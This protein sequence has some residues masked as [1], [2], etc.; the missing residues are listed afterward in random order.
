[1]EVKICPL[2]WH[3]ASRGDGLVPG[4]LQ[5]PAASGEVERVQVSYSLVIPTG[6]WPVS[7]RG[8]CKRSTALS[9][10]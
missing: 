10:A 1:M 8:F 7:E 9:S 3:T 4:G 5:N 2:A 6:L